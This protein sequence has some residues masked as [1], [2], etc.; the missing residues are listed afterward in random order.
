MLRLV[1]EEDLALIGPIEAVEHVHQGGLP[2]TVF[3][4]QSVNLASLDGEVDVV[5]RD[6]CTESLRN[7]AKFELHSSRFYCAR[8]KAWRK[9][10]ART[11]A[12]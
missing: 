7:A 1:V 2:G 6:Q 4:Q 11:K 9:A 8:S 12:A 10:A 3:T 5:I